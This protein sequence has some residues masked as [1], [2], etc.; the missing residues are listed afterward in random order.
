MDTNPPQDLPPQDLR[1]FA[2]QAA[3][4]L[5]DTVDDLEIIDGVDYEG[6]PAYHF[7]FLIDPARTTKDLGLV[8]LKLRLRLN[9]ELEARRDDHQVHLRV[10]DTK[11]WPKR[12]GG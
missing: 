9:D 10:M 1:E 7:T 2:L 4:A 5:A 11:D 3:R 12:N 8:R 6:R